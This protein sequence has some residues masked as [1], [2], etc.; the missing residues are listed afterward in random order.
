MPLLPEK[1]H[2]E[3]VCLS[4]LKNKNVHEIEAT[5]TGQVNQYLNL[6]SHPVITCFRVQLVQHP[7][8]AVST[9]S[10]VRRRLL[11]VCLA[12]SPDGKQTRALWKIDSGAETNIIPKSLYNQLSPKVNNLQKPTMKL[13]A[14]GG[15]EIPN[16]GS[17]QVFFRRPNN[18]Y[19][20]SVQAKVVDVDRPAV[21]D[22]ILAQS[23]NLLKLNRTDAV[24]SNS[25]PATHCLK[26]YDVRGKPHSYISWTNISWS[27]IKMSLELL[28]ASQVPHI[29]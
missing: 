26:L 3:K 17:C 1:G 29:T 4:N 11:E 2:L 16:L 12:L 13:T 21:V 14:Y 7:W 15:T 6:A 22:K 27:N 18:P 9:L 20:K 25:K 19:P 23:F 5:S 8:L 24:E 10:L 28:D